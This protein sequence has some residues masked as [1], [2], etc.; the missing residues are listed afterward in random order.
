MVEEPEELEEEEYEE[1]LDELDED[2]H[3]HVTYEGVGY[4]YDTDYVLYK[5]ENGSFNEVGQWDPEQSKPI[6][7]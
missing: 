5:L 3:T 7:N 2:E 1:E 6:L 4:I